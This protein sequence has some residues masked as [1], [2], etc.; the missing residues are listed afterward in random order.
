MFCF[1][2]LA[3]S[4]AKESVLVGPLS[5]SSPSS[6]PLLLPLSLLL[7]LLLLPVLYLSFSFRIA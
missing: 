7:P 3:L 4:P 6:S 1:G 5:S 2:R